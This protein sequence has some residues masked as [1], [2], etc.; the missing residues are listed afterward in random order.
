[1]TNFHPQRFALM[2]FFLL[3]ALA[4]H[5]QHNRRFVA[6]WEPAF[7]TLIRWPLGIPS[8][9]VVELA[10]D[11][12]LYVLVANQSQ[13]EQATYT[14]SS[15]N[16]NLN[17]CQ[18]I[19]APTNS[20]WTRDW[21]P[22][23][24]FNEAGVG[25]I[26]DPVF[27]GYPWVPG[28]FVNSTTTPETIERRGF[29]RYESDNLVNGI[30]AENFDLPLIS[31][32]IYLTGGNVMVDGHRTAIAT[33]QMLDENF[34]GIDEATFRQIA[35][36]SLGITNFIIVDNPEVHGIQHIDCYAKFLDEETILVKQV[37]PWHAEY[38]CCEA[39]A[40]HLGS[41]NNAYGEPYRIIRIY[42]GNY[43]GS[44]VAAYTN[45]LIL[46][47]KVLV[48]LFGL[49]ED[50]QA[51]EVYEEAMPGYEVIGFEWGAWYHYDA[52][53]CRTMGIFDHHMLRIG[54]KPLRGDQ[55]FHDLPLIKA[56]IDD[57]SNAGLNE[58]ELKLYWREQGN[59]GWNNEMLLQDENTDSLYAIIPGAVLDKTYDYFLSAAD[60]SGRNET[61][62]TTAPASHYTFTF[63]GTYTGINQKPEP[64][65]LSVEPSVFSHSTRISY[66]AAQAPQQL[67]IYSLTG[68][69]VREWSNL[70]I[71]N[72]SVTWDGTDQNG[73]KLPPGIYLVNLKTENGISVKKCILR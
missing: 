53:H 43:S 41:E 1:M 8:D 54:H 68:V 39:L 58:D 24:I 36:D 14:F 11:D 19:I 51:L 17:H 69:K 64:V 29:D 70:S 55:F 25:G 26:A 45:S 30:L 56:L 18:F 28:C 42:C 27:D 61:K 20:H 40:T 38:N 34:P 57:R 15:W 2:L 48:P 5:A 49:I 37:D 47:N 63:A 35:A 50:Q 71:G 23:Y 12:S 7:G 65:Q 9:L 21:G 13:L 4:S 32:P 67:A 46:N 6:E 31:L 59:L 62:P 60:L 33:Q 44:N 22:H 16:V 10:E 52:L 72:E 3:I 73:K 66:Q